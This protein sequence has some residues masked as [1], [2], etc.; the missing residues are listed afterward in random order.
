[1][2]LKKIILASLPLFLI[3]GCSKKLTCTFSEEEGLHD[4]VV[5][6]FKDDKPKTVNVYGEI[7]VLE[8]DKT[9]ED[10]LI[11]EFKKTYEEQG[12]E[13]V[14]VDFKKGKIIISAEK[15]ATKYLDDDVKTYDDVKKYFVEQDYTCK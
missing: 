8:E 14:E 7:S 1:M 11:S 13:N 4:K 15:D 5:V 6:T 12:Y 10:K 9:D 3:T 2:K